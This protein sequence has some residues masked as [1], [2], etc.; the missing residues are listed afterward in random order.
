MTAVTI[1][2]G[3]RQDMRQAAEEL[4]GAPLI[5]VKLDD[6]EITERIRAVRRGAPEARLI[7]DPNEAWDLDILTGVAPELAELGVEM[8]EQ[9]LPAHADDDLAVFDSPISLCADEGCHTCS[10]LPD[11]NSKY[12]MI[13]IKLDKTGGLTEAIDL[14]RAAKAAG[15]KIMVGCMVGT[16]LAMAPAALLGPFAEFVDLDGPL[17]LQQDRPNGLY[18]ENGRVYPPGPGLWG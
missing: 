11:L 18:F 3:T 6:R 4:A 17:L 7:V 14:A 9:P 13:N 5:K 8:I 2:I 12:G 16:S 1:G 10:D 15:F